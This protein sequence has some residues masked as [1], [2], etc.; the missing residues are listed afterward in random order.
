MKGEAFF[1]ER[2]RRPATGENMTTPVQQQ[3]IAHYE[4][5]DGRPQNPVPQDQTGN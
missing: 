1:E 4:H 3:T 5:L 2:R